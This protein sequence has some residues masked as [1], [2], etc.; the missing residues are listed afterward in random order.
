MQ[1]CRIFSSSRRVLAV[2][3]TLAAPAAA[4][5]QGATPAGGA[6]PASGLARTVTPLAILSPVRP[7]ATFSGAQYATAG[8]ALRNRRVGAIQISGVTPPV[9]RA[10][11]YWAY[12]FS[13]AAP[14]ARRPAGMS[15][16]RKSRQG[17][18]FAGAVRALPSIGRM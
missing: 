16:A 10:L 1:S 4:H 17:R 14:S 15:R 11:L 2:F 13:Y 18:M 12:L 3:L 9:K 7:S 8:V 6:A 5:A